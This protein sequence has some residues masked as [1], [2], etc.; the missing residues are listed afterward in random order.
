ML[1][2]LLPRRILFKK[3]RGRLGAQTTRREAADGDV[4]IVRTLPNAETV[5]YAHRFGPFRLGLADQHLPTGN[6]FTGGCPG[7]EEPGSPEPDVE[8]DRDVRH[9]TSDIS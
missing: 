9:Q 1:A 7:L 5:P 2:R 3:R 4:K 6:R 8:A